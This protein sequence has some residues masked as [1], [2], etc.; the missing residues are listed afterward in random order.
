MKKT[1][2]Y[3]IA[4]GCAGAV[5][6]LFGAGGGMILV[7]LLALLVKLEDHQVF[8]VSV[9]VILP[10]CL[11]S[12]L[13]ASAATPIP[14]QQAWPYLL[15]GCAGG[16]AASVWGQRIPVKWLH[17]ILGAMILWGGIRCLC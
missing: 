4:G 5:T 12:L 3:W 6:G 14:W 11:V 8:S 7:P 17:R 15:G 16:I 10:I 1:T 13:T 2:G 9:S